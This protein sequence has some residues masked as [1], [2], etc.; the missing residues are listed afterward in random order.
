M[1]PELNARLNLHFNLIFMI[2]CLNILFSIFIDL[3][4]P[5]KGYGEDWKKCRKLKVIT[6]PIILRGVDT[7]IS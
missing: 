5:M 1:R 2:T 7:S 3:I 4:V 6:K